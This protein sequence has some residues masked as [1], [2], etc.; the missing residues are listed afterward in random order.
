MIDFD[1]ATVRLATT[2]ER[3]FISDVRAT[4]LLPNVL[5]YLG[6][7]G[8]RFRYAMADDYGTISITRKGLIISDP[9]TM[10]EWGVPRTAGH[11]AHLWTH[12]L[13]NHADRAKE[14][15]ATEGNFYASIWNVAAD[16]HCTEGLASTDL[17][18]IRSDGTSFV[19][20]L[21]THSKLGLEKLSH[22]EV[23]YD[24][25]LDKFVEEKLRTEGVTAPGDFS[26]EDFLN[27][28]VESGPDDWDKALQELSDDVDKP[29]KELELKD[30]PQELFNAGI[31]PFTST[32]AYCGSGAGHI[33]L[34]Q[35]DLLEA[36]MGEM[37]QAGM[38]EFEANALR[39]A[40]AEDINNFFSNGRGSMPGDMERFVSE[41]L[42]PP[43]VPWQAK[44]R[45]AVKSPLM[46]QAGRTDYTFR[47]PRKR[48]IKGEI[49]LPAMASGDPGKCALA[50]DTSASMSTEHDL[51]LALSELEGI[52]K[53]YQVVGYAVDAECHEVGDIF[54]AKSFKLKGGGGTDM[55]MAIYMVAEKR[56]KMTSLVILTDG[57][58]PWPDS[59][60]EQNLNLQ[61]VAGIICSRSAYERYAINIPSWIE[62]VH[63]CTDR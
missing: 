33:P 37:G 1:I 53:T 5:P 62:P 42:R 41:Q 24:A 3:G 14:L 11:M 10:A 27:P 50:V 57:D 46:R 8:L 39:D 55:R 6:R 13:F 17:G 56:P 40:V 19:D 21:E 20:H 54:D 12:W 23:T 51:V 52:L 36:M 38:S 59:P 63:I 16:C 15:H 34:S 32:H 28:S 49:I 7:M 29:Q 2:L 48:Q 31:D 47:R 18:R 35:E 58:T 44:L 22:V 26:V 4:I 45:L 9:V 60:P 61:V 25:L 43:Q 30:I